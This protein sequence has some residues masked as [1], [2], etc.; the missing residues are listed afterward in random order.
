MEVVPELLP[1]DSFGVGI[2]GEVGLPP[3]LCCST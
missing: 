3:G 1:G 2:G